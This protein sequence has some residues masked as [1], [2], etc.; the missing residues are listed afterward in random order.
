MDLGESMGECWGS[1]EARLLDTQRRQRDG[2]S[3]SHHGRAWNQR[4]TSVECGHQE[5]TTGVRVLDIQRAASE[6]PAPNAPSRSHRRKYDLF[7]RGLL[8][9]AGCASGCCF[10]RA[11]CVSV[12]PA[13]RHIIAILM[14]VSALGSAAA[15]FPEKSRAF[16]SDNSASQFGPHHRFAGL[17]SPPIITRRALSTA[18]VGL[19]A[20]IFA[21]ESQFR[22]AFAAQG[23]S[24]L[25]V[26]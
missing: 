13:C 25:A 3:G 14:C 6:R 22:T 24:Q 9:A 26:S 4:G 18:S 12:P 23:W 15:V 5:P 19:S 1:S 7:R 11:F 2:S 21:R 20:L 16:P 10:W 8:I 17:R